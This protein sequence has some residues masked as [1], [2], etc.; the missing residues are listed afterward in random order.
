MILQEFWLHKL[1]WDDPLPPQLTS[2]WYSIREDLTRLARLSIPRWFNTYSNS[3]VE[4]HGFSDASQ[5]AMAAVSVHYRDL[6]VHKSQSVDT[7]VLQN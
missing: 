4:L 6:T 2:H 7:G 1:R 3:V 5:L